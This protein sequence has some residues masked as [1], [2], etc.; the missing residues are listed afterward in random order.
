MKKLRLALIIMLIGTSCLLGVAQTNETEKSPLTHTLS[1]SILTLSDDN[2]NGWYYPWFDIMYFPQR[3]TRPVP[4]LQYTLQYKNLYARV[5]LHALHLETTSKES[6]FSSEETKNWSAAMLGIGGITRKKSFIL[7]Y[8]VDFSSVRANVRSEGD[9]TQDPAYNYKNSTREDVFGINPYV[10]FGFPL[11]ERF[12]LGFESSARYE[13]WNRS[14]KN[15]SQN[16]NVYTGSSNGARAVM[17]LISQV[18][19]SL[20]L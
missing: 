7:T 8:G 2:W 11:G 3:T 14:W 13:H 16:G 5:G 15:S 10:G 9:Y 18:R 12:T 17:S 20:K 6:T 1:F 19:L 4:G